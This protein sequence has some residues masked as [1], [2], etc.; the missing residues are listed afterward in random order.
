MSTYG[1]RDG[2]RV[3]LLRSD[4]GG[5]TWS[6]DVSGG[7]NPALASNQQRFDVSSTVIY[8]GTA[9]REVDESDSAWT[10]KRIELSAGD[11]T[12]VQWATAVAWDDRTTEEYT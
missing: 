7:A 5:D 9:A 12:S 4:D 8:V 2:Q 11:P 10:I 3:V 6:P 1:E